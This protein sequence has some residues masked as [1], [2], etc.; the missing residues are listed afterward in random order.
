ML[1]GR[2]CQ[3]RASFK[4]DETHHFT[5]QCFRRFALYDQGVNLP[6]G[7]KKAKELLALMVLE[8]RIPI[9]KRHLAVTLWPQADLDHARDS[10]YKT[11]RWLRAQPVLWD[12]F[13]LVVERE[14]VHM[15][16]SR[17]WIDVEE[18]NHCYALRCQPSF[19]QR[20]LELY[21]GSLLEEEY[22]DWSVE[23]QSVYEVRYEELI[24]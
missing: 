18:F 15:D 13:G 7:C 22:Y 23:L 10:L 17:L 3:R 16:T 9:S 8:N 2:H 6:I 19:R 20:A 11:L 24:K 1:S 14:S 21:Q 12:V 4:G 5:V